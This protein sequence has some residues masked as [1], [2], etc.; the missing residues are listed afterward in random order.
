MFCKS[1]L[2]VIQEIIKV[3]IINTTI[4]PT[5]T[6]LKKYLSAKGYNIS[7]IF[8]YNLWKQ[9][10]KTIFENNNSLLVYK[11]CVLKTETFIYNQVLERNTYKI[12]L[13]V[14]YR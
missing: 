4:V 8:L 1:H 7:L 5:I 10:S 11:L 14:I 12:C 13:E 6:P 3:S 9:F 2:P